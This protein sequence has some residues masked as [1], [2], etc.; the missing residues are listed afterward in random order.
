MHTVDHLEHVTDQQYTGY[1][2]DGYGQKI[3]C[4]YIKTSQNINKKKEAKMTTKR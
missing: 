1:A 3:W 4:D 2:D